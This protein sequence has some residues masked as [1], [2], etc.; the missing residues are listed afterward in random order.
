MTGPL[1]LLLVEDDPTNRQLFRAVLGR[2]AD[3]RLA[4]ASITEV[5]SLATARLR[6]GETCP[7]VVVLD[8]RLP[9]GNGLDL[10]RALAARQGDRR[11]RV[12]IMSASVMPAERSAALAAGC[13]AFLGKPYP[14]RELE[15]V[16]TSL[17]EGPE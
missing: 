1:E 9:D 6:L 4:E 10:A 17:I 15:A 13:D 5:D 3:R 11:P 7:Q 14:P 2:S 12:L 8:V 16:L